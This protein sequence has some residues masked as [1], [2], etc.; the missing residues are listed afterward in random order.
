MLTILRLCWY[1]G[2]KYLRDLK[3]SSGSSFSLR[4]L[5]SVLA[6]SEFLVSEARILERGNEQSKKEAKD[7]VPFDRVKDA[8]AVARELRWR[9][10]LAMG[11]ASDDEGSR[12]RRGKGR[13][14][15]LVENTHKRKRLESESLSVEDGKSARFKNF[16]PKIWENIKES[17]TEDEKSV[18]KARKLDEGDSW[19]EQWVEWD[20]A[21]DEASDEAEV[22]RR[23]E[24]LVKVRRTAKGLER[25]RIERVIESWTWVDEGQVA[26]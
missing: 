22:S 14:N 9:V 20:N 13:M 11:E 21:G 15:G 1:V 5:S 23:R 7:Q 17:H 8:S 12:A 24:V 3:S 25:Q 26:S 6:L 18:H 19:K 4:V 2:D 10:R 16:K